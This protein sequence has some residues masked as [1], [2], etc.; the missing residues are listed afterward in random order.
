MT[1]FK[2]LLIFG[3]P[4]SGKTYLASRLSSLYSIQPTPLDDLFWSADSETFSNRRS[5]QERSHLLL[6]AV[7]QESWILEG[8]YHSWI[9]P[10]VSSADLIIVL[11]P[12]IWIRQLRI[13]KRYLLRKISKRPAKKES[14]VQFL[15]LLQYN[16]KFDRVSVPSAL[17]S[18]APYSAKIQRFVDADQALS[19]ISN[20]RSEFRK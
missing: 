7:S 13:S 20:Y 10:A 6:E 12:N 4:G 16:Q 8:V 19:W 17:R 2:H 11:S 15:T 1:D 5:E 18:F 3:A 9:G 14:I